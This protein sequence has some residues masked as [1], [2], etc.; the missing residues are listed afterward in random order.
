LDRHGLLN[1]LSRL[2]QRLRGLLHRLTYLLYRSTLLD[3]LSRLLN[4]LRSRLGG[5]CASR[6]ATS[7]SVCGVP[8]SAGSVLRPGS[9]ASAQDTE[10]DQERTDEHEYAQS[11]T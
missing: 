6:S 3:R 10:N 2:R 4:R 1:W 5:R 8:K 9:L 7:H 11:P